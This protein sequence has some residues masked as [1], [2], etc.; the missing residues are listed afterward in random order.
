MIKTYAK[1]RSEDLQE[2][3]RILTIAKP[4]GEVLIQG[5]R[6]ATNT[7][8]YEN[9]YRHGFK[10]AHC[11]VVATYATIDKEQKSNKRNPWHINVHTAD[12]TILTKDH[13]YPRDCGGFDIIENY[14]TL[15]SKCNSQ[16]GNTPEFSAEEAIKQG[17]ASKESIAAAEKM[18]IEREKLNILKQK[19]LEQEKIFQIAQQ[20]FHDI[21]PLRDKSEFFKNK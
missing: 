15:C 10:C 3:M 21:I 11:G 12:G 4:L 8:R 16:K 5:Y 18:K 20:E 13:I 6:I 7:D 19:V 9:F 2:T 1:V 14:Q 17:I